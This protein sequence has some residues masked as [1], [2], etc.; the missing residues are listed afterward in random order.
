[1][2]VLFGAF[3]FDLMKLSFVNDLLDTMGLFLVTFVLAD[4]GWTVL[5]IKKPKLRTFLVFSGLAVFVA[6]YW[7]WTIGGA[8]H[9]IDFSKQ[10]VLDSYTTKKN[11]QYNVKQHLK[12]GVISKKRFFTL[13]KNKKMNILEEAIRQYKLP[14]GYTNSEFSFGWSDTDKGV[15][16]N[17]INGRDTIWTLGEGF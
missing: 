9:S 6:V 14:A 11:V 1:M 2:L 15:R 5:K 13:H 10:S 7:S 3:L 17:L 16:I 4:M 12:Y 8:L